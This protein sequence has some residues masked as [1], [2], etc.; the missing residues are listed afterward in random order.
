VNTQF[1]RLLALAVCVLLP[2]TC[3]AQGI[4]GA[5]IGTVK[6][7][8]NGVLPGASVRVSSPVLIGGAATAITNEKGQLRFPSLP[9]GIYALDIDL[10]GFAPFHEGAIDVGAGATIERTAVLAVSGVEESVVVEGA[11]SRIDARNPG[12]GTRFGLQDLTSIPTR[13]AGMF[14]MIRAA[15]GIAPTSPSSGTATTVSAFGSGTNENQWLFDGTNF[16]CPCN[17]VARAEP[18]VDFIQ[19]IQV[20]ALGASAEF[21]N[22]QGAVINIVT[23]QG[24]ERFLYDASYHAQ[25][26]GSTSQPVT[27]PLAAPGGGRSGYERARS[28]DMTTNLGGPGRHDRLWFFTGYQYLRD[29][30]SQPGTDPAFP[31]T[32][33]QD[34]IFTKLTWRLSPGLLLTQS[35]HDEFW[36]NPDAPTLATPFEATARPHGT[37][38]AMTFGHLTHALSA[39]TFWDVRAGRFI[40]HR[41]DDP[42]TGNPAI[43][44]RLNRATGVTTGAPQQLTSL[45]IRRT[46]TKAT[47]THYRPGLAGADH[48]V[49]VGVQLERGEHHSANVIPTGTRYVDDPT[50]PR[51]PQAISRDV[52]NDG[53]AAVT[54]SAFVSD[55][56]TIGGGLTIT[57]GVRY[58]HARAVSQDL[59]LIDAHGQQTDAVVRGLG[60]LYAW[61]I[62]SPRLGV[63]RKLTSDGRTILRGSYGRFSQG[64]LTGELALFHP[65]STP[66]T[67][68]AFVPETGGFTRII[69]VVDSRINLKLDA[70]TRAPRTDEYSV[71]VDRE[72]ARDVATSLAYV[73][74]NGANFIGWTDVAGQY[75]EGVT[76]LR[77]GTVVPTYS[78]DTTVTPT[79]ARR[80]LLTNPDGY[81]MSYNG[82]VA[83]VEKRRAHGWQAFGSYTYSRTYGLLPSSAATPA[84]PQTSTVSPPNPITFGR[85]PNDLTN[86][87]G[88]LANDRPHMVRLMGGADVPRT[89]VTVS[90]NF[91]RFSGKP[92][93]AT[94]QVL[95]PQGDQRILLEPRGARRLS[96]QS[97]LDIR[98]ARAVRVGGTARVEFM[99]D[100]L[101]ALNDTAEEG[102]AS[103]NL[104]SPNFGQPVAFIDPRR[105]MLS[106]RLN[107][108]Q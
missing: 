97:L 6:D 39:N 60:T 105:V 33:D 29:Y 92:W 43:A 91:Q 23:R 40:Y 84:G 47:V 90:G 16:T 79:A 11:G 77:N 70:D 9:P 59:H 44:S 83:V 13:R 3:V 52:T 104:F 72:V 15:P 66:I 63:T 75:R 61:N 68:A 74:K 30:D 103:D 49:K 28:R 19:E 5:L 42:S 12:V 106:V 18:G 36:V 35:L 7:A 51:F 46:T 64:V 89:G 8:L 34:K 10:P 99:L 26:A 69:S 50:D 62:V 81:S 55:A 85:D 108:G 48:E 31:R 71:G 37:V 86:A 93:A 45:H 57:A 88:R 27:L 65:A 96:A 25:P 56:I 98:I 94:T 14:D 32:Y 17:G 58:D 101:N 87:R 100:V 24:S 53:G 22:A 2:A 107:V 102:L 41:T 73:R 78:L 38:P 95:L 1:K 67:T 21:G 54:A 20:Q 82:L 76:T 80:F 4:T